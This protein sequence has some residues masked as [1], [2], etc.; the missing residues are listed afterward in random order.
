MPLCVCPHCSTQLWV[1]DSQLNLAQG[2]VVCRTC[3]GLFQARSHTRPT[4]ENFNPD[5]F[6]PAGS[7]TQLVH[8]IGPQVRAQRQLSRQEIAELLDSLLNQQNRAPA[9]L[10][11][12]PQAKETNWTLPCMVALTVLIIQIFYLT[13]IL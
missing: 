4:P 7:D 8:K 3:Q 11:P 10:P 1:K 13:I 9:A 2:Y 5:L 6:P 12:P